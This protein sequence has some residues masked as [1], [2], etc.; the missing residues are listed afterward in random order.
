MKGKNEYSIKFSP[1]ISANL[2]DKYTLYFSFCLSSCY[3]LSSELF[4]KLSQPLLRILSLN[5]PRFYVT[6]MSF[7]RRAAPRATTI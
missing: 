7:A 1:D 4:F 2:Y 5:H 3:S 6:V